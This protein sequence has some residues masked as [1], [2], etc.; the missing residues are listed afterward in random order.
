M[1]LIYCYQIIFDRNSQAITFMEW[2]INWWIRLPGRWE[3]KLM[4][5][6]KVLPLLDQT[7]NSVLSR[8]PNKRSLLSC[9][10]SLVSF[11]LVL[12]SSAEILSSGVTLQIYLTILASFLSSVI[13]TSSSIGQV[14]P[15]YSVALR[16]HAEYDLPFVIHSWFLL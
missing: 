1:I 2:N 14:S 7:F 4:P 12:S 5:T 6:L 11:C 15:Q 13:R 16:T 10:H 3:E 9:K 8:W